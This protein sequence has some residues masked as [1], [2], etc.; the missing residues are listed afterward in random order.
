MRKAEDIL[1]Y[2]AEIKETC[3][4][5]LKLC[6]RDE[7]LQAKLDLIE[8][9]GTYI[10][11]DFTT[12]N[13]YSA[14][15]HASVYTLEEFRD[16]VKRGSVCDYDGYGYYGNLYKYSDNVVELRTVEREVPAHIT[17]VYWLNK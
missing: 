9:L 6:P 1:N 7:G 10:E 8:S 12:D 16:M 17:H 3:E 14:G 4:N 2:M 15:D 5:Y 13:S 11:D